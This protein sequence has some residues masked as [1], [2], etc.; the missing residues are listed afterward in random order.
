MLFGFIP[1]LTFTDKES[2]TASATKEYD[3]VSCILPSVFFTFPLWFP[4]S[5]QSLEC[6]VLHPFEFSGKPLNTFDI[7][8]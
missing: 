7:I 5:F 3:M 8:F 2:Y 4:G 6:W 1:K